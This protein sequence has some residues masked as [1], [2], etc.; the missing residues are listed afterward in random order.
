MFG[1]PSLLAGKVV[2]EFSPVRVVVAHHVVVN[3][4]LDKFVAPYER[5]DGGGCS[6]SATEERFAVDLAKDPAVALDRRVGA[7]HLQIEDE[8]AG[9][10]RTDHVAQD[11]HDVLG[12]HSSE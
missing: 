9:L 8:P 3:G 12:F 11:V 5:V 2:D 4:P 7:D 1:K 10:D 6:V